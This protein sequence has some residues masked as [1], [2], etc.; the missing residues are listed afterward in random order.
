MLVGSTRGRPPSCRS[1]RITANAAK[2]IF[3]PL[4]SAVKKTFSGDKNVELS[5]RGRLREGDF[6]G[7]KLPNPPLRLFD[8]RIINTRDSPPHES[9]RIKV[10]QLNTI[11]PK[12][13]ARIF[14]PFVFEAD[15]NPIIV[16]RPQCLL[17]PVVQLS[18]PFAMEK[19]LGLLAPRQK[20]RAVAPF[21]I[22][23]ICQHDP[24]RIAHIP[25]IFC[26]LNLLGR[27][28]R[29]KWRNDRRWHQA[30]SSRNP[31]R[32]G[33]TCTQPLGYPPVL[34]VTQNFCNFFSVSRPRTHVRDTIGSLLATVGR[35]RPAYSPA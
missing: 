21:R 11:R 19:R 30:D 7:L 5:N 14:V 4:C 23:G 28:F 29:R 3:R 34:E 2:A 25:Q 8:R 18:S 32:R 31:H 22:H 17:Q 20:F 1:P 6:R 27:R 13:L 35:L 10:P 33:S 9:F 12:P 15:R 26:D 24:L 16:K